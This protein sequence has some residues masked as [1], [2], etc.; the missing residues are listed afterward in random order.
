MT[1]L[2]ENFFNLNLYVSLSPSQRTKNNETLYAILFKSIE[3]KKEL[4]DPN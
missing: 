2:I 1:L 3:I 4:I